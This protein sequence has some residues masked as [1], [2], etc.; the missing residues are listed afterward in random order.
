VYTDTANYGLPPRTTIAALGQALELWSDGGADWV[1]DWDSAG[2]RCRSLFATLLHADDDEIALMPAASVGVGLVAAALRPGGE[3]LIPEDEF[4]SVL[5]PMLAAARASGVRVRRVP[6]DGLADEVGPA[7]TLVATSHV[8]SNGGARQDLDAVVAAA[9]DNDARVLVDATHSAGILDLDV[10][11]QGI[12]FLVAAA[13]KHLL[14]PR[15]VAFLYVARDR[16]DD[17][18]PYTSSWRSAADPYGSYYGGDL[19]DL[20]PGAP[21][22]DVSLA[23]HAW[24]GAEESLSLLHEIDANGREQWAV[25][26]ATRFAAELDVEPTGTS[27]VGFSVEDAG[28]ARAALADAGVVASF[29]RGA[30]RVSFHVYNTEEDLELAAAASKPLIA[31]TRS[32]PRIV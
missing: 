8:R 13:Y 3:V 26:L 9:R 2:D 22:F 30:A 31:G 7:T 28:E 16:W 6:F 10:H 17:L 5:F 12:D 19:S 14:C 11:A 23:W 15:G 24:V 27:I 29:P 25:G 21:R 18:V 32:A 20:A 1:D 4:R